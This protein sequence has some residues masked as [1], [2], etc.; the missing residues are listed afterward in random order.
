MNKLKRNESSCMRDLSILYHGL[1]LGYATRAP[2]IPSMVHGEI[3]WWKNRRPHLNV[4]INIY[5]KIIL[6][7][8]FYNCLFIYSL[9]SL[10]FLTFFLFFLNDYLS[11]WVCSSFLKLFLHSV[12]TVCFFR[13]KSEIM[14]QLNINFI[15]LIK[16]NDMLMCSI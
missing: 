7:L 14:N 12:I 11:L 10:N 6:L 5:T 1:A 9:F 2:S 13:F 3:R 8:Q 16:L 15:T 4:F